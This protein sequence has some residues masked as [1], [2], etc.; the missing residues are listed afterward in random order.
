MD[1]Q[2]TNVQQLCDADCSCVLTRQDM[3]S[4][5][6]PNGRQVPCICKVLCGSLKER[7]TLLSAL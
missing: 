7:Q 6:A 5:V 1:V 4:Q 3:E 2:P